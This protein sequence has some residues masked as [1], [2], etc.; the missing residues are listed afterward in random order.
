MYSPKIKENQVRQLY[1]LK[2]SLAAI[3]IR[4]P[5]TDMVREALDKY[6]P[7]TAK[8]IHDKDGM[9]QKSCKPDITKEES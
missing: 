4:K 2:V 1:K 3:G 8:E 9:I 5:M 7:E 6:I